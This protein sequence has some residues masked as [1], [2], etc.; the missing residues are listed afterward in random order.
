MYQYAVVFIV[1]SRGVPHQMERLGSQVCSSR[2]HLWNFML[3][4]VFFSS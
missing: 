2:C 3:V 1:G 4:C